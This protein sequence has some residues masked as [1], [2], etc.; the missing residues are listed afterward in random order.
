L[1]GDKAV[2]WI[3]VHIITRDKEDEYISNIGNIP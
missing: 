2:E 3:D 1:I